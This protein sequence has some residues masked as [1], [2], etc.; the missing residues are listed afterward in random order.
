ME[1]NDW[2]LTR[3]NLANICRLCLKLSKFSISIFDR[4]DP[5]PNKR[6]LKDRIFDMY[7][8]K[9]KYSYQKS[10]IFRFD[11]RKIIFFLV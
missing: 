7:A 5:N 6:S 2:S 9:V 3:E 4:V 11:L 8:I 10:L 1:K